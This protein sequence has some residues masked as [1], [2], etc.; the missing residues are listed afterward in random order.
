[1]PQNN[2]IVAGIG[3]Q[4][5][6]PPDI[7]YTRDSYQLPENYLVYCGRIS[8]SKGCDTLF[9]YFLQFREQCTTDVALLVLGEGEYPV[10]KH[11]SIKALGFV[12]E[13]DKKAIISDAVALV[14]PSFFE[15][16]SIIILEAWAVSTPVIVNEQCEVLIE[17]CEKSHGGI[18][19]KNF[20]SFADACKKLID[21][22]ELAKTLGFNGYEYVRQYYSWD[23]IIRL[24]TDFFI[25]FYSS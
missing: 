3:I 14:N 9:E 25:D 1:M 13:D 10:P 19:F 23:R 7:Q 16:L 8:K 17:H 15:S 6:E 2:H 20:D 12:P 18:G 5:G 4:T 24:Y 21:N 22:P 11:P